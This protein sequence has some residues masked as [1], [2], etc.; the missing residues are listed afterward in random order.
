MK[1]NFLAGPVALTP[2]VSAAFQSPPLSHREPAFL[3]MMSRT[4]ALLG[5]LVNASHTALLVGSGTLANDAVAAQLRCLEGPGLI[6][7]NGEFGERLIDHAKRWQLVFT[8]ERRNWGQSFEWDQVRQVADR[9]R[10][11]WIWAV[12]SETS[13]GV[14]NP[15]VELLALS[16]SVGADLC[17]D[18]V[19]AVGLMPVDLH[20]VRFSTAV[21]GK[22][23]AALPGLAAVF[24]CGRLA[25]SEHIPRYL[26]LA[27]YEAANGVP[28]THSSNLLAALDRSLSAT[29]WLRKFE[30]VRRESARLRAALCSHGLP[31]V[32]AEGDAAPGIVT[33]AL[34]SEVCAAD[35]ALALSEQGFLLAHQSPYLQQRNWLQICLMGEFDDT[36]VRLLPATLARH[37]AIMRSPYGTSL[38]KER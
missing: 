3:E 21:S 33:V 24:H 1:A 37:V 13:T 2:E 7:A 12:L 32:A 14:L 17:L 31:P 5:S 28:F 25:S 20:R 19:S 26:D 10:P 38:R 4:R 36:A 9:C 15:L 8:A 34:S 16:D 30:R 22:G 27:T 29:C 6:L 11:K 18:A 35:V 23:L